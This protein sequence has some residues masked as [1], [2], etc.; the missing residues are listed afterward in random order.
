MN[1]VELLRRQAEHFPH[2]PAIIDTWRGQPRVTSFAELEQAA[3]RGA[4]LLDRL[5]LQPG[6]GVLVFYAMSGE[7]YAAML[8]LF[9][10]GL[11][12]MFLDP[13]AGRKHIERCCD[14]CRPRGLIA[15]P[16]AHML[17]L[18]SPALRSIE[19]KLVIGWPVPGAARWSQANQLPPYAEVF[20]AEA[21]APALMTFTSGS[22]GQPKAAVRS[23]GFLLA[24]HR[25]LAESLH[26]Q[27]GTVDLAT[28]PIVLLANLASGVTS[29]IPDAD[30]RYPG[31][32]NPASVLDQMQRH[33][34]ES[35][36]ASPA[37]FECLVRYALA[38][39]LS[40]PRMKRVISGGAPVFPR[41]LDQVQQLVPNAEIVAIYGSTEAEPIAH[42]AREDIQPED[43]QTML[44]GHGLLAGRP[45]PSIQLRILPDHWG[46]PIGPFTEAELERLALPSGKPGEIVVSGEHVLPGYW[47]GQ[48]D[49]ETKFRVN[50]V[51]WHRT[52]DAGYLDWQGRLW[53]LGRCAAR[54][55]DAQ[56]TLFPFSVECA[57]YQEP[58]VRHAAV[59]S[60][61]GRRVLAV[62]LHSGSPFDP[63]YLRKRL[64]WSCLDEVRVLPAM[65]VDPRHNAKIDYPK[66][67][68]L[69]GAAAG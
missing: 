47:L 20:P 55:E 51:V 38:K 66:L 36:A 16:K 30:L 23:H 14:L 24:Q 67:K 28:L 57:A 48:G 33:E 39:G 43:L 35:S 11:V 3:A 12:A 31:K 9:R 41:L 18:V 2:R 27:A 44:S 10:L 1:L 4:T 19:K 68:Q 42:V 13:S 32:I 29:V 59:I 63:D 40:L 7:L 15:S 56:G 8:A 61:E 65:P 62:E 53:L 45:V 6:D 54:I 21:Q 22:T 69:L 52:G 58:A 34:V 37:F 25:V 64:A 60:H 49:N 5:G 50:D 26:L 46:Q 17:R